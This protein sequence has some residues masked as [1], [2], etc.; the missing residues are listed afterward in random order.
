MG[1]PLTL[2]IVTPSYNTGRYLGA[3]IQS[4]LDQ[5]WPTVD[6]IVMDGGSTDNSIDVLRAFGPRVRWISEK[7]RGQSHAINMGFAK[8]SGDILGWLNSDDMY[9]PGAFRAV[10][11]LFL[12]RPDIDMVYGD[13]DYIT[14][15]GNPL[16]ACTHIEPYNKHRLFHY[17]DFI[18]QPATFFRRSAFE[19]AG[20]IDE[21]IHWAMDY[22]LWLRIAAKDFKIAYLPKPLAHFR[23]LKDNKT[24]TGGFERL[25]EIQKILAKHGLDIPAFNRLERVNLHLRESLGSA[26]RGRPIKAIISLGRAI[27]CLF[28]S[29][30]AVVSMFQPRTWKII[31]TG[32]VLRHRSMR[33]ERLL[34]MAAGKG[35]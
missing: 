28:A 15:A 14:P 23:W 24:A 6:Y 1:E 7:D 12:A 2:S 16:A 9:A 11:E 29:P 30:R 22:D 27:G 26:V 25:D 19:A 18:V 4:V 3:A 32:Q 17:S 35:A 13:A 8:T 10:M 33:R 31:Y 5:D 34:E 20:G 21:S